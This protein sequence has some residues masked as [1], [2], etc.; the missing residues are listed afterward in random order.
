MAR[1]LVHVHKSVQWCKY[2]A[3]SLRQN[4][5]ALYKQAAIIIKYA[6]LFFWWDIIVR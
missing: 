2:A 6:Y 1:Q 3:K 4:V 5:L